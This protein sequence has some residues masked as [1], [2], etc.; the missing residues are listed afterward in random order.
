MKMLSGSAKGIGALA[1]VWLAY[2]NNTFSPLIWVLL[3]LVAVDLFL[4]IHKEG[5]Q[6]AKLGSMAVTLGIPTIV[7]NNIG[8]PD[9][10]K[11]LVAVLCLA[12]LQIVVPQIFQRLSQIKFSSNQATNKVD[13]AKIDAIV[14]LL[15]EREKLQAQAVLDSTKLAGTGKPEENTPTGGN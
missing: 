12:Y 10:G 7:A 14:Q 9:L 2:L 4:N 15:A 6:F 1:V 13:Q 3:G 5:Q 8:Q 11:Y